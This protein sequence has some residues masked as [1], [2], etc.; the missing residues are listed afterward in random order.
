MVRTLATYNILN[1]VLSLMFTNRIIIR[2]VLQLYMEDL[3]K[4]I[5]EHG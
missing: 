5:V 2:F 4:E 3:C 1:F